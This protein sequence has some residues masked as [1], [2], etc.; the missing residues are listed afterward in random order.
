MGF[1]PIDGSEVP[2]VFNPTTRHILPQFHV[3]FDD[4]FSTIYFLSRLDNSPSFWNEFDLDEFLY[5]IS[6]NKDS[7]ITLDYE[8]LTPQERE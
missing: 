4:S 2:L 6:L 7:G 5:Q 3:V 8:C 1:S